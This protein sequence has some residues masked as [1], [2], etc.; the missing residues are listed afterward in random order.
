MVATVIKPIKESPA[1]DRWDAQTARRFVNMVIDPKVGCGELRIMGARKDGH[2]I[3]KADQFFATFGGWYDNPKKLVDDLHDVKGV[4]AYLTINP[5]HRDFLGRIDNKIGVIEKGRGTCDTNIVCLRNL[6]IDFDAERIADVSATDEERAAAIDAARRLWEHHPEIAECAAWGSSGNG[7]WVLVRLPDLDPTEGNVELI[8]SFLKQIAREYEVSGKVKVDPSTRN[9][10]RVIGLIGCLKCKG[11]N[12]PERPWRVSTIE[13]DLDDKGEVRER[14]VFDLAAWVAEHTPAEEIAAA[15]TSTSVA[16]PVGVES[17][18]TARYSISE[19]DQRAMDESWF[20]DEVARKYIDEDAPQAVFGSHGSDQLVKVT[21][22]L[23]L[24]CALSGPEALPHLEYWNKTKTN[25]PRKLHEL[26]RS[27]D[28]RKSEVSSTDNMYGQLLRAEMGRRKRDGTWHGKPKDEPTPDLGGITFGGSAEVEDGPPNEATPAGSP[29][30]AKNRRVPLP[31]E[32]H[33]LVGTSLPIEAD[34]LLF[35][36]RNPDGSLVRLAEDD[37]H[38]LAR[39]MV[40]QQFS[41][42]DDFYNEYPTLVCHHGEFNNWDGQRYVS[43]L[44]ME[45][46]LQTS[47]ECEFRRI[48]A[49]KLKR[50]LNTDDKDDEGKMPVAQKVTGTVI[51]NTLAALKQTRHIPDTVKMPTWLDMAPG[52][53]EPMNIIPALNGLLDWKTRRVMPHTPRYYC[54][55]V[56][57]FP[58]IPGRKAISQWLAF[59]D[60]LRPDDPSAIRELQKMMFYILSGRMD[61][62][63]GF[64]IKGKPRSGKGTIAKVIRTLMGSHN[65]TGPT[66]TGLSKQFGLWTLINKRL[67]IVGDAEVPAKPED[68]LVL[69]ERVKNIIGEDVVSIDRK[70]RDPIDMVLPTV[71]LVL[72]NTVP[73][74]LDPSGA[75]AGRFKALEIFPTFKDNPNRGLFDDLLMPE[76]AG[77]FD[78][79]LEGGEMLAEDREFEVAETSK[80]LNDNIKNTTAPVM[81]WFDRFAKEHE[82]HE[83]KAAEGVL[84]EDAFNAWYYFCAVI[85]NQAPGK[86]TAFVKQLEDATNVRDYRTPSSEDTQRLP[87]LRGMTLTPEGHAYARSGREVREKKVSVQH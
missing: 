2:T 29:P 61:L 84:T 13:S 22:S 76:M 19:E 12:R 87:R 20:K 54:P 50:F 17:G 6:F 5:V 74:L 85:E 52:D 47:I 67:A 56:L 1:S 23:M 78:W 71:F 33:G 46:E 64:I 53:P 60:S 59:L 28:R 15:G 30:E 82:Y 45:T 73:Q 77:I 32:S 7:A 35:M 79:A 66:F 9:P 72:T 10:S 18:T 44:T 24:R 81:A 86:K 38:R 16:M 31:P 49:A 27:I 55:Y 58:Y 48:G 63:T 70:H 3:I 4:S 43:V 57:D 83:K 40:R 37:P 26:Q 51:S 68:R 34:T 21:A 65:V 25:E 14:K 75:F 69:V 41:H 39:L 62:H 36:E 42:E 11:S 8:H 80:N